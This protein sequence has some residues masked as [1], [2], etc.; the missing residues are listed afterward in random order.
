LRLK[1]RV[2][3]DRSMLDV[4]RRHAYSW[5]ITIV[6][7]LIAL[8]FVFWG[9]GPAGFEEVQPIARV[10]QSPIL[11]AEVDRQANQMR[12]FLQRL[13]GAN[14][15]QML[16]TIDLRQEALNRIIESRLIEQ[17]ARALGV[18]ITDDALQQRIA[19]QE[20]FQVDGQFDFETYRLALRDQNYLP[21]EFEAAMRT[22]MINEFMRR[23]IDD[24]VQVSPD[25]IRHAFNLDSQRIALAYAEIRYEPFMT[26]ISPT[27]EEVAEFYEKNP[28]DFVQP[29]RAKIAYIHYRPLLIA[30]KVS[31]SDTEIENYYNRFRQSRFTHPDRVR[32]RH[33]LVSAPEGAGAER[34][35]QARAEAEKLRARIAAGADFAKLADEHS[36]DL[37]TRRDGGD[38][39][40]FARG[41]MIKPFEEA[42]F[43]MK[44]GEVSVV[45][46]EF[47]FHVVHLDEVSPAHTETLAQAR[48]QIIDALRA[49]AGAKL[50]REALAQDRAA[51]EGGE[52]LDQIAKRRGL[53]AVETPYFERGARLDDAKA[54]PRLAQLAFEL[55]P[56]QVRSVTDEDDLY[57]MKLIDMQPSRLPPLDEIKA[58][59]RD[60]L[61][62]RRA[63][64]EAR[65]HA[66]KLLEQI[67]SPGDFYQVAEANQLNVTRVGGFPRRSRAVPGI[68]DFR[69]VTDA[70]GVVPVVPGVIERVMEH[71]GNS[72]IFVVTSRT[73]PSDDEWKAAEHS[74]SE[75]YLANVRAQAWTRFVDGLKARAKI[76]LDPSLVGDLAAAP[77]R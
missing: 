3:Y 16:R 35:N 30:E 73:L 21:A 22:E 66:Q 7:G 9:I 54:S 33:I 40:L 24:A 14:A 34:R 38:L 2:E 63:I 64:S 57:L 71:G 46:T 45:E 37:A 62:R 74:F 61:I 47:G 26:A 59:V 55:E 18:R 1:I 49:D 13:Y 8:V 15:A 6:L 50:A 65:A 19:A 4:M 69:E 27:D 41:Q 39:G 28:R 58:E 42:V 70:A 5:G 25:E 44:P 12:Q 32:A 31:P 17:E 51:A 20:A 23:M 48:P 52:K 67:K 36:D 43:A 10:N 72:Y 76:E 75:E 60:V 56:G 77:S 11:P 29:D 68:G 53:D